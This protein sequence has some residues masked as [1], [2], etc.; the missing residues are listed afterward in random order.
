MKSL[1]SFFS[2]IT[3]LLFVLGVASPQGV[4]ANARVIFDPLN[5][6]TVPMGQ[7]IPVTFSFHIKPGFHVN[8][9][10]PTEP[11]LIPTELKFSPPEDLVIAKMQYPAGV[12]TSFPFDPNTKLSVY[13][14]D[15]AVKAVVM[16]APKAT[17]GNYTVHGELKYQACDNNSCYP[18]KRLPV[19]FD[20]KIGSGARKGPTARPNAQSPHIHN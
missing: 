3:L 7:S 8:S 1:H 20:V 16:T 15:I 14:G 11:E 18:P 2:A 13:S 10:Q 17:A 12:L 5:T 4:D 19:Q 6:V 9:H